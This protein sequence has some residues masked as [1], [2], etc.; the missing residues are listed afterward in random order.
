MAQVNIKTTR[1][2]DADIFRTIQRIDSAIGGK[3]NWTI[4]MQ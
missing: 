3:G 2:R 1:K 4:T